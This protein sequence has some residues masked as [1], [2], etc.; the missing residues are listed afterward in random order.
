M[1]AVLAAKATDEE[2]A[3]RVI[4]DV[5]AVALAIWLLVSAYRRERAGVRSTGRYVAGVILIFAILVN[6]GRH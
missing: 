6:L 1:L 5:A 2:I 3:G 4:F